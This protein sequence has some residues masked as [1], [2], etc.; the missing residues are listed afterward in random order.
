MTLHS[1]NI[2]VIGAGFAGLASAL[3]L[4]RD[5]HHVTVFEKFTT[6]QAV[7]AG[8]LIQPTGLAAMRALGIEAE[9]IAS[10]GRV[11]WLYGVNPQGR[12]VIDIQYRDW[13]DGAFG[14]GLHRGALFNALWR[15]CNAAGVAMQ[16][17]HE[18]K[19]LASIAPQYDITVI[20]DGA[21]SRLRAQSGLRHFYKV[22]PWGALW[23]VLPDMNDTIAE[24]KTLLQWY[25]RASKMMGIMPTGFLPGTSTRV[26]S[27]FWSLHSARLQ[28]WRTNGLQA[29]KDEVLA[30]SAEAAPF[31]DQITD[32]NQLTWAHYA[33]V[34]MPQY[35]WENVVVIGD[36]AHAT[37][38][39]LGQGTNMALLDAVTL[40]RSVREHAEVRHA[41]A[42]YTR[43]RKTH[44]HYYGL[45]SR[46]LTPVFQSDQRVLP[47]LRD[48][49]MSHALHWPMIRT[50]NRETLVGVRGGWLRGEDARWLGS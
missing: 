41:L 11:D 50:V 34:V 35:H 28:A 38:P 36:A 42:T 16:T 48:A 23:A 40:A 33:D 44:L 12:A 37:S 27:L 24:R 4:A 1:K 47:W 10:G 39:Q 8:I 13:H 15:E 18:V 2:A 49:V 29:W 22:Y 31:L 20:A 7:G 5:G 17:G 19:G 32:A 21:H 43:E 25:D 9:M 46:L 30:L 45:A 14:L 26:V 6:P 3:L